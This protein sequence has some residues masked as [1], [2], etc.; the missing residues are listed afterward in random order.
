MI[1]QFNFK[2]QYH[3]NSGDIGELTATLF[4]ISVEDARLKLEHDFRNFFP[5]CTIVHIGVIE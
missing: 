2:I 5:C 1:E 4:G 3:S